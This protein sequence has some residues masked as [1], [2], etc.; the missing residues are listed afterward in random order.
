MAIW[1]TTQDRV[2]MERW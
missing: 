1:E 2:T